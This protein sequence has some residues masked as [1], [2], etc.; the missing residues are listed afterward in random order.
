M[1][2]QDRSERVVEEFKVE[3]TLLR[4]DLVERLRRIEEYITFLE[5]DIGRIR[6]DLQRIS[7]K[8]SDLTVKEMPATPKVEPFMARPQEIPK[9]E[10]AHPSIPGTPQPVATEAPK[11]QETL[12]QQLQVQ[13][14][15]ERKDLLNQ[16]EI[17]I[18]KYLIENPGTKSATPIA[19]AINKAREHVARTL[20]K[21]SDEKKIIRDETT[22]PYSYIV[23][24]EIKKLVFESTQ[25]ATPS[26][27][28]IT[29][30]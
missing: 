16:T 20:K 18:I 29:T 21:L 6:L 9:V 23:P 19:T 1:S 2:F 15:A 14:S 22:W 25:S 27:D 4:R 24:D 7:D 11:P 8:I 3:L 5:S 10:V 26:T 13:K 30:H 28:N 12:P 17:A